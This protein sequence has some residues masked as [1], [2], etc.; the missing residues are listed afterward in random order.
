MILTW[1][2][3]G[4]IPQVVCGYPAGAG[5]DQDVVITAGG[6]SSGST[7]AGRFSFQPPNV[8]SVLDGS[9]AGFQATISG[10]NFGPMG[11]A[12]ASVR[13]EKADLWVNAS[14]AAEFD[15]ANVRVTVSH[16]VI[17]CDVPPMWSALAGPYTT[18]LTTKYTAVVQID[19]QD[20]GKTNLSS[21]FEQVS[22]PGDAESSLGDLAG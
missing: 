16:T 1:A 5:R 4:W 21:G 2:P 15:C 3:A 20:S 7:G 13:F 17:T 8:T 10:T 12:Y 22:L 11:T 6:Q 19:N 9:H 14:L 18:N